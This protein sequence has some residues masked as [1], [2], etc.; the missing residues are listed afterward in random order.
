MDEK[1]IVW[2]HIKAYRTDPGF[3][4]RRIDAGLVYRAR[5]FGGWLVGNNGPGEGFVPDPKHEWDGG[6]IP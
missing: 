3:P 4:G 2:E 5:I 1:H 6:S